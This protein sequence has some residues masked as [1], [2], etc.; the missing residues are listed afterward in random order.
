MGRALPTTRCG[1]PA[2][3]CFFSFKSLLIKKRVPIS[4]ILSP[5]LTYTCID[6]PSKA[7]FVLANTSNYSK[8]LALLFGVT[9]K[10]AIPLAAACPDEQASD[11]AG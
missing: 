8:S 9:S 4:G 7:L 11:S 2:S 3:K 5:R 10:E 6:L 1:T